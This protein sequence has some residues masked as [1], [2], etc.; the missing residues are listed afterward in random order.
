MDYAVTLGGV[1]KKLRG[2][3]PID[4]ENDITVSNCYNGDTAVSRIIETGRYMQCIDIM[5]RKRMSAAGWR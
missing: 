4:Y 1:K 5:N 3:T 2:I